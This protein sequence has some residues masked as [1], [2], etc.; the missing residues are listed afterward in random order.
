MT[1]QF[2]AAESGD[3]TA[4]GSQAVMVPLA[5]KALAS[6]PAER[7][8]RLR[9]HL[10]ASLRTLRTMKGPV[11]P[12][13]SEPEGFAGEV[14]RTACA[15]CK[16]YCC[17]GGGEHAYLD[18]RTMGRVRAAW[19]ELEA[20]AVLRLYLDRVP[21]ESYA[22]SC[23]FHGAQGCTLDRSLRADLCN[24]YYCTALGD[25]VRNDSSPHRV[26]VIAGEG[27]E[28][29]ISPVL[30]RGDGANRPSTDTG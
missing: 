14:A 28:V 3:G 12:M 27:D 1:T 24:V 25:F 20:R 30:I 4:G 29:R 8:R 5:R 10:I 11:S 17:K 7:V 9:K 22:G 23:I 15:L 2:F 18:E 21:A 16:G 6:M 26:V 19:P 13:R